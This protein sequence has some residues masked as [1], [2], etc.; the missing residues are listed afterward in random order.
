M[1]YN[2]FKFLHVAGAIVWVG[3]VITLTTLNV[4]LAHEADGA[5]AALA[6][7]SGALGRVLVGPAAALT[8]IAGIV[9][10]AVGGIDMGA[11]WIS[12]GFTGIVV[13]IALG[14]T[15][16]R[17]TTAAL[18]AALA[19]NPGATPER[20]AALRSR[21]TGWN[22]LNLVVLLSVVGAMVF[23]PTL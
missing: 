13:S 4:R 22:L 23:K 21:L 7:A 16:I 11:L 9:T 17:R 3:G 19:G 18:E 8:L 15:V 1:D 14:A 2:L 20:V 5:Q 6:R 12:W 10:T